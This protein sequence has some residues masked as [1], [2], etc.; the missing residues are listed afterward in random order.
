[1]DFQQKGRL[2]VGWLRSYIQWGTKRQKMYVNS[3]VHRGG[4]RDMAPG[5][6]PD[7]EVG[8]QSIFF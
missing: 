7:M 3:G 5:H 2:G 6:P 1:M 4:V 8:I